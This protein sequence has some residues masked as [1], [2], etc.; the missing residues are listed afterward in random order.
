MS[1]VDGLEPAGFPGCRDCPYYAHGSA[2]VCAACAAR[3]MTAVPEYHC[4]VCSQVTDGGRCGN[5][6]CGAPPSERGFSSVRAVAMY[7]GD[8][9]ETIRRFK[10][11][12]KYGWAPIFG[13]LVTGWLEQHRDEVA[14][15]D[16]IVGNPTPPGRQPLQHIERILE[17][18]RTE[19]IAGRWPIPPSPLLTK[20]VPTPRSATQGREAKR[21]A[22]EEHAAVLRL[23]MDVA[24]K[25][26]MLFDDLFTT[27]SQ[28]CAVSRFLLA[29]GAREVRGLVLARAPWAGKR[30]GKVGSGALF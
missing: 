24:G 18:A 9:A 20:T 21:R 4:R 3:T 12:G 19:D 22:A 14:D 1:R 15:I 16:L 6:L 17:A 2:A 25:R 11:Q 5:A 23:H 7:S 26:V 27:G 28:M 29:R 13:R 8:L 30:P 10:Y